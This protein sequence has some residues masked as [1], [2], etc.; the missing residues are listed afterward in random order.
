M[1]ARQDGG[2]R[3]CWVSVGSN[4][5]RETSIRAGVAALGQVFGPLVVSPVYE[6]EA[7]GCAGAPFLNLVV[8]FTTADPVGVIVAQLRAIEDTQGR[9][10]VGDRF[11]PRSLDLDLLTWGDAVGTFDGVVLPRDEVLRYAFVLGPLADVAPDERHP[12]DGR[13][14]RTLWAGR[15]ADWPPLSRSVLDLRLPG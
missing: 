14:Y 2:A 6:T 12:T 9:R 3:R 10:R 13:T 7:V 5:D 11:A 1:S 15:D 4:I 8:G